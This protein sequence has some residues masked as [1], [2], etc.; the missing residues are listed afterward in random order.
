MHDTP[1]QAHVRISRWITYRNRTAEDL[2]NPPMRVSAGL[3]VAAATAGSLS[4]GTR[5]REVFEDVR[6]WMFVRRAIWTIRHRHGLCVQVGRAAS[7]SSRTGLRVPTI[8]ND[9]ADGSGI[10]CADRYRVDHAGSS[11]GGPGRENPAISSRTPGPN[12]FRPGGG[13]VCPRPS[14]LKAFALV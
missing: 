2:A 10:D 5:R 14:G 1:H 4:R 9:A 12:Q 13:R 7:R 8:E 11:A 3:A 6:P